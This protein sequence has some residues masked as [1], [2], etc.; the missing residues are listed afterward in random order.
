MSL[1]YFNV[2]G[3]SNGLGEDH[4]PETHLIPNILRAA[5]GTNPYVEIYG[6]DYPYARRDRDPGLHPRRRSR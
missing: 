5:L 2:A 4:D 6:T 3:A 1:R